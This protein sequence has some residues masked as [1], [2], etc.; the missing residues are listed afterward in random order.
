MSKRILIQIAGGV[1]EVVEKPAGIELIIRDYDV[2]GSD[3]ETLDRDPGGNLCVEETYGYDQ[4]V[5]NGQIMLA[6]P[7]CPRCGSTLT[8][9]ADFPDTKTTVEMWE[10]ECSGCHR[11]FVVSHELQDDSIQITEADTSK[12]EVEEQ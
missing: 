3:T 4:I 5:A 8:R 6:P 9:Y 11:H 7:S 1:A 10:A 12:E 2:E